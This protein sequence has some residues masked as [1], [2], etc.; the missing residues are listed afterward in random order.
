MKGPAPPNMSSSMC[1]G[2]TVA[3]GGDGFGLE[4]GVMSGSRME[5]AKR[6]MDGNGAVRRP[7]DHTQ[8][9]ATFDHTYAP[10]ARG[11]TAPDAA[12]AEADVAAVHAA[13]AGGRRGMGPKTLASL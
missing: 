13:G 9:A 1:G 6:N 8:H 2:A 4:M 5:Y 10:A 12:V 7:T 3:V 11:H